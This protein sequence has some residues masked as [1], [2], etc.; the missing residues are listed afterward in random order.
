[1][2]QRPITYQTRELGLQAVLPFVDDTNSRIIEAVRPCSDALGMTAREAHAIVGG[3][4]N[5]V[6][7]RMTEL[8]DKGVLVV[9]GKRKCAVAGPAGVTV[10]AWKLRKNDL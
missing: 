1:M 6:R 7:S 8:T 3:N 10:A 2:R 4:L 5:N 9:V